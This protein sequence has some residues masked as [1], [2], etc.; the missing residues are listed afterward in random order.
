M[1]EV[2]IYNIM[3]H[4]STDITTSSDTAD[5]KKKPLFQMQKTMMDIT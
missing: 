5:E 3:L 2:T 1:Q 4:H